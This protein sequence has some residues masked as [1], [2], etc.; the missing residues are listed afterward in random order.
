MNPHLQLTDLAVRYPCPEGEVCVINRLS[1]QLERGEIGC[2]LGA[3]GCGKTTILRAI[4]GFE[5]LHSWMA[6]YCPHRNSRL[7]RKSATWA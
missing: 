7:R 6:V 5:P 3:S 2:L 4:A 1:L